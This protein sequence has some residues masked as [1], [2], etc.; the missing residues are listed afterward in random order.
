MI[1]KTLDPEA[2]EKTL[3]NPIGVA[4]WNQYTVAEEVRDAIIKAIEGQTEVWIT[5]TD[6]RLIAKTAEVLRSGNPGY[7]P[8]AGGNAL[9]SKIAALPKTIAEALGA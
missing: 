5:R 7:S 9:G 6:A 3:F 4:R 1:A 2:L 8:F